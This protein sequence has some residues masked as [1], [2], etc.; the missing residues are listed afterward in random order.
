MGLV[1]QG[2]SSSKDSFRF[3]DRKHTELIPGMGLT[4]N[5]LGLQDGDEVNVY[6]ARMEKEILERFRGN[7]QWQEEFDAATGRSWR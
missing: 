5:E 4:I 3:V 2:V 7:R 1:G 6:P